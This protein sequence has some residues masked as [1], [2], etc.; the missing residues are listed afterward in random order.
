MI[1]MIKLERMEKPEELTE[2]KQN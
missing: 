2:E 1:T